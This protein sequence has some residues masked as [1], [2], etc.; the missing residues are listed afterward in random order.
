M[1]IGGAISAQWSAGLRAGANFSSITGQWSSDD[2]SKHKWIGGPVIGGVGGYNFTETWALRGELLY[3]TMG[4]KYI[5]DESGSKSTNE[6]NAWFRER[7]NCMQLVIVGQGMWSFSQLLLF[8]NIGTFMTMKH[9]GV[10]SDPYGSGRI[11]WQ[12]G[13]YKSADGDYYVDPEYNRR[14]DF[15]MYLGGGIG[16]NLGP[17]RLELDLRFGFGLIDLNKFESKD[18]KKQAKDNGYRPYRSMNFSVSLAYLYL[19]NKK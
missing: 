3:I 19:F 15:G 8:A 14:I 10:W 11:V 6:E 17:G 12:R 4:E 1:L 18:E 2:D 16:K 7:Y 5:Y 13:T 9:G